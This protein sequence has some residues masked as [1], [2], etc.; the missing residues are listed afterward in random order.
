MFDTEGVGEA[1]LARARREAQAM[2]KL[3]DAPAHRQVSTPARTH[4]PRSSS[5]EY[6]PGGDVEGLLAGPSGADWMP[7]RRSSIAVDVT[8]GLEHA[9][10]AG[11]STAT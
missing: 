6:M 7:S 2:G 11:S 5:A 8:R 4:R 9:H 10:G 1:V 3:G